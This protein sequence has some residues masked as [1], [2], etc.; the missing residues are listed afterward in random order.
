VCKNIEMP[1]FT[2][3]NMAYLSMLG[4]NGNIMLFTMLGILGVVIGSFL[5]V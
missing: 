2:G 1:I 3:D 4:V 5:N